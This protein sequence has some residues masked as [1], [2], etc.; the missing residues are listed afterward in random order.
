MI[1]RL[2]LFFVFLPVVW[3]V[4]PEL[5]FVL[6][7][8]VVMK[9][10]LLVRKNTV[11]FSHTDFLWEQLRI[12]IKRFFPGCAAAIVSAMVS[13]ICAPSVAAAVSPQEKYIEE[14][15]RV[16]VSEMYRSGV[17]AS[18]TLA[19]GL[20]ESGN[21]QSDLA[22]HA[23]NHFGIKC[24]D[25]KGQKAYY[26][27]D[28]K[29]ECFRKYPHAE[30]SFRDHSDFLRY[31]DRYKSLFD[32]DRSDYKGWAYGLKKAGYATDPAYPRKLIDL[33][34]RYDLD[35]FDSYS[36][37]DIGASSASASGKAGKAAIAERRA[38]RRLAREA[39][40]SARQAKRAGL[41]TPSGIPESPAMIENPVP[42]DTGD[43][44]RFSFSM[45]RQMYS[46]NRVPFVYSVEGET[47]SSIAKA[48]N[49]FLGEIL[50]FNDVDRDAELK[51]G[52]VVY[53]QSKKN[54]AAR[55]V[56][57]YV[58]EG[59]ETLWEIAQ[60]FAVKLSSLE[61][62]NGVDASYVIRPEDTVILR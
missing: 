10:L 34:E 18:I 16:A 17:P 1:C 30:A 58:A 49:L 13:V 8:S 11:L 29:G 56:D 45:S 27:D 33:I 52:S 31:R 47:Y 28:R 51:P 20:L 2:A 46:Q 35:R 54:R 5:K 12:I 3:T 60:R 62:M 43:F 36:L 32:L 57:K 9:G 7:V 38:E 25:W 4:V 37:S 40:R 23:N 19:Q 44:E 55:L 15:Y 42:V 22:V 48:Y 39:R 53:L 41:S 26:D 6:N 59:G 14:W 50:R 21:G 61:K 24:H